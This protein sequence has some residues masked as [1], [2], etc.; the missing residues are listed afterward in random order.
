MPERNLIR[1]FYSTF[2]NLDLPLLTIFIAFMIK[3][4]TQIN[5]VER[6]STFD[7]I[8]NENFR[9][10]ADED[11]KNY[12]IDRNAVIL[13]HLSTSWNIHS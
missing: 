9:L 8:T 4:M 2:L 5:Y 3:S 1:F 12:L 13:I 11:T 10:A 6:I 7:Q